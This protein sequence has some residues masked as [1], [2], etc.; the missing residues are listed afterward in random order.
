MLRAPIKESVKRELIPAKSYQAICYAVYDLGTHENEYQGKVSDRREVVLIFEI[1]KLRIE[2]LKDGEPAEGPRVISKQYTFS[3]NEKAN[4]RHDIDTWFGSL[5]ELQAIDFDFESLPGKNAL[6]TIIHR[7]KKNGDKYSA[8]GSISGLMDGMEELTAENPLSFF[9]FQAPYVDDVGIH[10]PK[11]MPDWIQDK[12]KKSNEYSYILDA[13]SDNQEPLPDE[14]IY[15]GS[16]DGSPVED[17]D[18]NKLP[19]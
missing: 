5:S 3:M 15:E 10:F 7:E 6:L 14:P 2:Y 16:Q 8:I 11:E 9:A 13:G 19:F 18:S 1:P 12:I 17:T 4:L